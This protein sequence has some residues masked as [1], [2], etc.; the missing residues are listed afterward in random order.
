MRPVGPWVISHR[1]YTD[2]VID[3]TSYV[4]MLQHPRQCLSRRWSRDAILVVPASGVARKMKRISCAHFAERW[5]HHLYPQ[6]RLISYWHCIVGRFWCMLGVHMSHVI[7]LNNLQNVYLWGEYHVIY[8]GS[9]SIM[10]AELSFFKKLISSYFSEYYRH[11]NHHIVTII[12]VMQSAILTSW[13]R[14]GNSVFEA[15][16]VLWTI[17]RPSY[18]DNYK[19][20]PMLTF[21]A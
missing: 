15:S 5:E 10:N 7:C 21:S 19:A 18:F 3:F 16:I 13:Y 17:N 2:L 9:Q 1:H 12:K 11:K 4:A 8:S 20:E 14:R 6:G